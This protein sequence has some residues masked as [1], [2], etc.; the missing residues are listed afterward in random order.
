M[1]CA[2]IRIGL[3]RKCGRTTA[4]QSLFHRNRLQRWCYWHLPYPFGIADIRVRDLIDLDECGVFVLI[5]IS[6]DANAQRWRDMWLE[7]V[8]TGERMVNFVR[9]IIND[10][11]P[12][13]P[14]RRRCFI[15]DNL[16]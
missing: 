4:Y 3:T 1:T 11:G 5:A 14:A 13:T 9:R 10:I 8:T 15:M 12:G 6:G 7:G 2:E 16:K